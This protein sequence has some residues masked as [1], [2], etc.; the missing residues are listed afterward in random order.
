MN[1]DTEIM[2]KTIYGEARGEYKKPNC[3]I[4]SLIA[5]GNVIMNRHGESGESIE[6]VCLKPRQFSCWN[7]GDI[8]RQLVLNPPIGDVIYILCLSVA[9]NLIDGKIKDITNGAN[10][11]HSKNIKKIPHWAEGK[12]PVYSVGNHI[13]FR[14]YRPA[15][16]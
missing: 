9:Q 2:A 10:H 4:N 13:F 14:L 6:K 15:V 8:N 7:D 1:N 16:L 3:G 12:N 11:Y 5:V